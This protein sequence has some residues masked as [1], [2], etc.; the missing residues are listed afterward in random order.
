[1]RADEARRCSHKSLRLPWL[2]LPR[3]LFREAAPAST[4]SK[5]LPLESLREL[6]VSVGASSSVQCQKL[7]SYMSTCASTRSE[8][9]VVRIRSQTRRRWAYCG[10]TDDLG[11]DSERTELRQRGLE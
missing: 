3:L 8:G 2:Q 6:L 4:R 5:S 1:M 7:G 10:E 11:A 9:V